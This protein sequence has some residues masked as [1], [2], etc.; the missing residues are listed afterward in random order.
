MYNRFNNSRTCTLG[1]IPVETGI[2]RV[3]SG[4]RFPLKFTL[5]KMG[6]EMT[7]KKR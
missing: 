3:I 2:Q 1:V 5:M 7:E 6:A 4:P